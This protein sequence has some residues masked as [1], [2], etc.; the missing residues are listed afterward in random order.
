MRFRL[1]LLFQLVQIKRL[2]Q[3]CSWLM[4]VVDNDQIWKGLALKQK[5]AT[6]L[7]PTSD[8][9]IISWAD[10]YVYKHVLSESWCKYPKV[11]ICSFAE[12]C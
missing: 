12:S 2:R 6:A 3:V 11:I 7:L 10:Y 4:Y 9:S 1:N 8:D 5:W